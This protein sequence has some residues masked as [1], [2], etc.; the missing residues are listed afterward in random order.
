MKKLLYHLAFILVLGM[1][2]LYAKG[3]VYLLLLVLLLFY[4]RSNRWWVSLV[5]TLPLFVITTFISQQGFIPYP[6]PVLAGISLLLSIIFLLPF[7]LDRVWYQKLPPVLQCLL[8]PS[9]ANL[10]NL[11]LSQGPTGAMG[12]IANHLVEWAWL[13]QWAA[14]IGIFGIGF[15]MYLTA[16]VVFHIWQKAISGKKPYRLAAGLVAV[17]LVLFFGGQYR[18]Q[19]GTDQLK[20]AATVKVATLTAEHT[21]VSKAFYEA[22][23]GKVVDIPRD[24]DQS[25]P[26]NLALQVALMDFKDNANTSQY[27][28]VWEALELHFQQ[29]MGE[30]ERAVAQGAKMIVFSEGLFIT[31]LGRQ[32][33]IIREAKAFSARHEVY[34]FVSIG[35]LIPDV[36]F[37]ENPVI[38]NKIVVIGPSGEVLDTYFKNVPVPDIDPSVPGDGQMRAIDTP[39]GR[40]AY[41]ICYDTDFPDLM[42]Q[43]GKLKAD[44]LVVPT[45]DW[46]AISPYHTRATNIRSIENGFSQVRAVS[47]GLSSAVDA[48][49]RYLA[50]DDYFADQDHLMIAEVPMHAVSTCYTFWGEVSTYCSFMILI[51]GAGRAMWR[52]RY[53]TA[54][55]TGR[56]QG[57][58]KT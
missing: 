27:A 4:W 24:M 43:V 26:V 42:R 52:W 44:L 10:F 34:L 9:L 51:I 49:G 33:E 45:G 25:D 28:P 41:A 5:I 2:G 22:H 47:G 20:N 46:K 19:S 18:L 3:P 32:G 17:M 29:V 55:R 15:L 12:Y 53:R 21:P 58:L 6:P 54:G 31:T 50:T 13:M 14:F 1:L 37:P 7:L 56:S 8:L 40:V 11:Y 30:A 23:T 16:T 36:Q 38:E 35:A 48:Y 39:Y 57:T